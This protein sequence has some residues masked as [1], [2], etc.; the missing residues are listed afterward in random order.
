[1]IWSDFF[2]FSKSSWSLAIFIMTDWN[3]FSE[4]LPS[5][6]SKLG[7]SFEIEAIILSYMSSLISSPASLPP[8]PSFLPTFLYLS[9]SLSPSCCASGGFSRSLVEARLANSN[10]SEFGG[11][12]FFVSLFA[13]VIKLFISFSS[14]DSIF[15]FMCRSRRCFS[16]NSYA[17]DWGV[18]PSYTTILIALSP[19]KLT[20]T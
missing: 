2:D 20:S 5:N 14:K 8:S 19:P 7:H 3:Y 12:L 9:L 13:L 4:I 6:W 1:M 18:S 16:Q 10:S 15:F 11:L 17:S